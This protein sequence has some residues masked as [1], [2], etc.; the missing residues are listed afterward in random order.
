MQEEIKKLEE[1]N[2]ILKNRCR[3]L[4][5]GVM[6]IF[7]P[8]ECKNRTEEFGGNVNDKRNIG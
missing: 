4:S 6:C 5:N 7:C 3:I 8:L 2:R 1:E